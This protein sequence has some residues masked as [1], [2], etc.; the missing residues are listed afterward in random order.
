MKQEKR[1]ALEEIRV[2]DLATF[3]AAPFCATLLGEFGAEVIKVEMPG[4]GDPLR[5][6]GETHKGVGLL[7]LQE[8]RTKKGV[9]CDLRKLE[10]QE[11]VRDLIQRCDMVVENFRPGTLEGW[12]L[13]YDSLKRLNPGLIMVRISAYGQTGPYA[14]KAGFGRIAQA[15]GGITYL[16]GHPDQPPV[17]PGSATIADYAAGLF[18]AYAALAALQHR[19][20][21]GLGQCID[22]S[23]YESVFRLLDNLALTYHLLGQVRERM[24]SATPHAVPHDHYPTRD[25]KW[26]AIACT[27]DRMFQRLARAMGREALATDPRY[28]AAASRLQRREEVDSLVAAWTRTLDLR[29]VVELLDAHEVPVSPIYSIEDIFRDPQYL[30]RGTLVELEDPVLG[31]VRMPGIVPRMSLTPGHIPSP[32]PRLGKH[33]RDVYGSLLGYSDAKLALLQEKGVI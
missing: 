2:L 30:A 26:V 28:A 15:F 27:N 17:N 22:V 5:R 21:T 24:G 8:A 1:Q 20:R 3:I 32:G 9:T 16:T 4:E 11:I 25:G 10:G 12:G 33:N 6:L 14:S 23:L 19:H 29:P 31:K 18:A 7:W 13:G